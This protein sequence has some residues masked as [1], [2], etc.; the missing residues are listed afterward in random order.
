MGMRFTTRFLSAATWSAFRWAF[1]KQ[2]KQAP[3]GACFY[4]VHTIA[5]MPH[6]CHNRSL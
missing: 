2:L 6:A 3:I 4:Y 1:K 5:H